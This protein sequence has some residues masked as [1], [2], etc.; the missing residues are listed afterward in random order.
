METVKIRT[1][2]SLL[3]MLP[4]LVG[5][6]EA[7]SL[8]ALPFSRGRS[9]MPMALDLPDRRSAAPI[10]HAV[11]RG[12]RRADAVVLVACLA[13]PLGAGRLPLADE[14]GHVAR[15]LERAG[16]RVLEVLALA[17][18]AWGDYS[19]PA[20][21]R[22]PLAELELLDDPAPGVPELPPIPGVPEGRGSAAALEVAAWL[23][24]LEGGVVAAARDDPIAALELAVS[25]AD[26][27]EEGPTALGIDPTKAAA[28]AIALVVSPAQRDLAIE[29]AI[30]GTS[31]AER[32]L[33]AIEG[34][35]ATEAAANRFLGVGPAPDVDRLRDRLQ[36]WTAI[37][38]A[39]PLELRAPVLVIVGFLHFFLGRGRSAGRCAELAMAIDP[40]LTMAPLLRDIVDAKGAPDWVL[41]SGGEA[42]ARPATRE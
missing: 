25:L 33:D 15:R 4:R 35:A 2:Q 6:T 34:D 37:A 36:R 31:S 8:V 7:P 38:E 42:G 22:G 13:Q 3:R 41:W 32:T 10:A 21:A 39:T 12:A 26:R 28:L 18:D 9:G 16:M 19:A 30:D 17:P 27:L 11:R 1:P 40:A 24:A 5:H 29:L 20:G 14:L 23:G